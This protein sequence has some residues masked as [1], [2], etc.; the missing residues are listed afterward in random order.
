[1]LNFQTSK[2]IKS[3]SFQLRN[4]LLGGIASLFLVDSAFAQDTSLFPPQSIMQVG[5]DGTYIVSRTYSP[6]TYTDTTS[7]IQVQF[8]ITPQV[9]NAGAVQVPYTTEMI[10]LG[11]RDPNSNN[12]TNADPITYFQGTRVSVNPS[13]CSRSGVDNRTLTCNATVNF[14]AALRTGDNHMLFIRYYAVSPYSGNASINWEGYYTIATMP[15][16]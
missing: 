15:P 14:P 16:N 4:M 9:Q 2:K 6:P 12:N 11:I 5:S 3:V 13:L 7:N 1:M 10:E 8:T